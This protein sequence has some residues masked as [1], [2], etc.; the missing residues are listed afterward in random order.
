MKNSVSTVHITL[1][2]QHKFISF[3]N[4]TSIT[5][6]LSQGSPQGLVLGPLIFILYMLP[7]GNIIHHYG[8]QFHCH[9]EEIQPC[10][11]TKALTNITH[12]TATVN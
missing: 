5:T 1:T 3:K 10:T 12:S 8:L 2:N 6:S 9:T 4:C 11:A 7:I